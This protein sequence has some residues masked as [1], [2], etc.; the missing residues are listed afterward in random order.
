[1]YWKYISMVFHKVHSAI[2]KPD[3]QLL[4]INY[5][6]RLINQI[7]ISLNIINLKRADI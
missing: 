7:N 3:I 6:S 5:F 4:L 1:M 2:L